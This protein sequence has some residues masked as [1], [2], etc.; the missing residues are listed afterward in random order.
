MIRDTDT[1]T[2]ARQKLVFEYDHQGRRIQKLYFT[3]NAGWNDETKTVYLYDSWNL[4]GELDG[5]S[6][7]DKLRTYVWGTDL[8]GLMQGAGAFG[9]LLK[10]TDY[11]SGTTHH[12]VA[13]DGNGNIGALTD[14][15]NGAVTARTKYG[16]FGE[17]LRE[18]GTLA[19]KNPFRFSTKFNDNETGLLY[20]GYRYYNPST[21][22]WKS[23]DP[24]EEQGDLNLFNF[25]GNKP[26]GA[27]DPLGLLGVQLFTCKHKLVIELLPKSEFK[28]YIRTMQQMG[29]N[30]ASEPDQIMKKIDELVPNYHPEGLCCQG[31]CI[32]T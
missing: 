6:S 10:V 4:I 5:F 23:R 31:D 9:G 15:G 17:P 2:G 11:T 25:V 18:T 19:K 14:A 3:Y 27:I 22:R 20:Y 1:P 24:L 28:G 30:Y 8:S 26:E 16:P 12:F 21:G 13:Y 7:N 29:A 32:C